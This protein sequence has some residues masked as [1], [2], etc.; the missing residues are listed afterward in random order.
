M[1]MILPLFSTMAGQPASP[2]AQL[3]SPIATVAPYTPPP[4]L[5][6]LRPSDVSC[7]G[8]PAQPVR[9]DPPIPEAHRIY[10]RD[11]PRPLTLRFAIDASGR[12]I[13]IA[14]GDRSQASIGT[15]DAVPALATWRFPAGA[16]RA[17]CTLTYSV[18]HLRAPD[19]SIADA[20]RAFAFRRANSPDM[21][22]FFALTIP[23][24]SDCFKPFPA[25]RLRAFP[26][27]EKMKSEPGVPSYA[28]VGFDIDRDGRPRN[29]RLIGGDRD[30]PIASA[31]LDAVRHSRFVDGAR[32]GCAL[33]FRQF[34]RDPLPA[35]V[36]DPADRPP[37]DP[38]CAA[39]GKGWA[40]MPPLEFPQGFSRRSIEG[41]ATVRFDVAP[42]G[43]TGNVGV[44]QS[45]PAAAFGESAV[46]IV[47]MARKPPSKLGASGCVETV[48]FVMRP[49]GW[50][51]GGQ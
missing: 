34:P 51:R 19:V 46:G 39:L 44:V 50:H 38:S 37:G 14:V 28:M 33:P 35:P 43:Q 3:A 47:Q 5:V 16:P 9:R 41:W 23:A 48:K 26:D 20:D 24:G 49:R 12:P 25:F 15:D 11:E 8:V 1:P 42:W 4:V 6:V 17:Q 40:S 10:G 7:D 27:F 2:P 18:E 22:P 29:V 13:D 31:G 30:A 21:R 45:E 36:R 32:H